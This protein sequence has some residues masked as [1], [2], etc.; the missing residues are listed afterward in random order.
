MIHRLVE[1]MFEFCDSSVLQLLGDFGEV[2]PEFCK[3]GE[4][5]FGM[6]PIVCE[7]LGWL[8]MVAIGFD[9]FQRHGIYCF[10]TNEWFDVFQIRVGWILSAGA[11][12]EQ[13]L[14]PR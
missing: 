11:G 13:L 10:R 3:M 14:C 1:G 5:G 12:P 4:H 7:T 8:S 2:D 9:R 6:S